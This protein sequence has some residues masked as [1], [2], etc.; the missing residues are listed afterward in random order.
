MTN[1]SQMAREYLE[2]GK[3]DEWRVIDCHTHYGPHYA[4]YMPEGGYA[5]AMIRYMDQAGGCLSACAPHAGL[6]GAPD[7]NEVMAEVAAT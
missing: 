3:L 2:K 5:E 1:E 4:I 7:G 6:F